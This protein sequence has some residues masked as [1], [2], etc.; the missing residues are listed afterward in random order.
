[1]ENELNYISEKI[2]YLDNAIAI[3]HENG[4]DKDYLWKQYNERQLLENILNKITEVEL[5][6][7]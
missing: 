5:T 7:L 1:M 2:E 4:H 3:A 6:T